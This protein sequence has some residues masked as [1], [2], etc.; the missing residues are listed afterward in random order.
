MGVR[1]YVSIVFSIRLYENEERP[2][3]A[4]VFNLCTSLN[5]LERHRRRFIVLRRGLR[6]IRAFKSM[7]IEEDEEVYAPAEDR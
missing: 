6:R 3:L 4:D 5:R 7:R 2:G 1:V